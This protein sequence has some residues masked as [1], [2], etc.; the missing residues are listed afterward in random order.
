VHSVAVAGGE[1]IDD[2]MYCEVPD[3]VRARGGGG[4]GV[5]EGSLLGKR[6]LLGKGG[7]LHKPQM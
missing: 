7:L 2:W 5:G 4:R 1:V 3:M 6:L